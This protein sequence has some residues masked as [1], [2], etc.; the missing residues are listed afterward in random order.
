V[1]R[2]AVIT[3]GSSGIG[4]AIGRRLTAAG[5]LCV[6]LARG[7]E[8]LRAVAEELGAEWEVCDVSDREA[9]E[10]AAA[11]ISARHPA[12]H[13]LVCSA[14][15]PGRTG[16]LSPDAERIERV[17]RV[18]YLGAVWT[19]RA[20]LPA[21]EAGA[22]SSIVNI[23]STAGT[24]AF[25]P[26][27]PYSASKH[28]QVALGRALAAELRRRDISVHNVLPGFVET[29]GFPQGD[30][31]KLPV[32]GRVVVDPDRVARHVLKVISRNHP[33]ETHVP[34]WYRIGTISQGLVPRIVRATVSRF[35]YGK[36]RA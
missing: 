34:R 12:I 16:F 15:I 19:V 13:L 22:P 31:R 30:V 21:L 24:V 2:I 14:G 7:E 5:W 29:P 32:V 1:Q 33:T 28:A 8:R 20:F 25:P 11:E 9:V 17:M 23:A 36:E 35:A 18:N 4:A 3:G 10:R 27:G 6:L 26:S